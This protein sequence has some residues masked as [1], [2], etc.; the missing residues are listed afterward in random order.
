MASLWVH[1]TYFPAHCMG[2]TNMSTYYNLSPCCEDILPTMIWNLAA[3]AQ[4]DYQLVRFIIAIYPWFY[5]LLLHV[6]SYSSSTSDR[7]FCGIKWSFTGR[8]AV[9]K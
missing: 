2:V 1:V 5:H 4:K 9:R 7:Y 6:S 3:P 8:C